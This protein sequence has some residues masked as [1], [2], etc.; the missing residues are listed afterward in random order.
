MPK[1]YYKEDQLKH[2]KKKKVKKV[3]KS[4]PTPD[5]QL[6]LDWLQ[7]QD[8]Q[9]FSCGEQKQI[10]WHHIKLNSSSKKNHKQLIPLCEITCHTL[11]KFSAHGNPVW[12]RDTFPM[13]VQEEEADKFYKEFLNEA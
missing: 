2:N 9:C 5:E 11:G 7:E 4:K 13:S 10:K 12:F 6:Y 1:P 3:S 8:V